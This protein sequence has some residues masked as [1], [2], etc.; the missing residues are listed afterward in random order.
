MGCRGDDMSQISKVYEGYDNQPYISEE[1]DLKRWEMYPEEF[2]YA[3][4]ERK[5]MVLLEEG[6]F[7]GDIVML[8]RIGFGNF[9]NETWIPDYFEYR[10]GV[11]AS[12]SIQRLMDAQCIEV[13]SAR[14]TMTLISAPVLKRYLKTKGLK[15]AGKKQEILDRVLEHFTEEE[16]QELTDLRKY[17]ATPQGLHLIAKY[18]AII[19]EHGPKKM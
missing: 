13:L 2:P 14:E 1:R 19:Q 6:L 16:L 11:K 3:K 9:T 15:L 5:K 17:E 12:E 18:D 4:V 7:P 8:W 10:Y